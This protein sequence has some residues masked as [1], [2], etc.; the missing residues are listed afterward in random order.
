M[1]EMRKGT[2]IRLQKGERERGLEYGE[3]EREGRPEAIRE[4]T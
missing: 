1:G 2:N 3:S 4:G